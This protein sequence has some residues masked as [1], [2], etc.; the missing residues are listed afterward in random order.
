MRERHQQREAVVQDLMDKQSK[1]LRM[2]GIILAYGLTFVGI[3]VVLP[4][5]FSLSNYWLA[6]FLLLVIVA[7]IFP[8][9]QIILSGQRPVSLVTFFKIYVAEYASLFMQ[10]V[11]L[12]VTVTLVV[13]GAVG[14]LAIGL[15]VMV[16]I[17]WF[18]VGLQKLGVK[19]VRHLP[20]DEI[21]LLLLVTPGLAIVVGIHYG[22]NKL[23]Q[24]YGDEFFDHWTKQCVRIRDF[25][26][27]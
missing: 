25:F 18:I 1:R 4:C 16:V 22:L 20:E 2:A 3:I 21:A 23:L 27:Y 5:F 10:F 7:P 13:V 6:G 8:A 26:R 19:I 15:L 12:L 11:F 9:M 24:K 14:R 17:G